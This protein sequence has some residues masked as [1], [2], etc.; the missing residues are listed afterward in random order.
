MFPGDVGVIG[1]C[2]WPGGR[3]R[4]QLISAV[5][6]IVGLSFFATDMATHKHPH[7]TI[8]PLHFGDVLNQT[9]PIHNLDGH[10]S[11]RCDGHD[12]FT[13]RK[14]EPVN[15]GNDARLLNNTC[16]CVGAAMPEIRIKSV[17]AATG[18]KADVVVTL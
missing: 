12:Q 5:T 4:A 7:I 18:D 15:Y 13:L 16:K 17:S 3:G 2:C 6:D 10:T 11:A 8:K 14:I 1:C 9:A